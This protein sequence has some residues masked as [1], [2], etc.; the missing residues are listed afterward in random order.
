MRIRNKL[1]TVQIIMTITLIFSIIFFLIHMEKTFRIKDAEI[2]LNHLNTAII[3]LNKYIAM[4][5]N[6][7]NNSVFISEGLSI[8]LREQKKYIDK[9]QASSLYSTQ[10]LRQS[11]KDLK[12]A[13]I[14]VESK[15][16]LQLSKE[17]FG[18]K[19]TKSNLLVRLH[20]ARGALEISKNEKISDSDSEQTS[21]LLK[22]N[23]SYINLN[24]EYSKFSDMWTSTFVIY[25]NRLI[26]FGKN[27]LIQ[28][29]VFLIIIIFIALY[30]SYRIT[31]KITVNLNEVNESLS[32]MTSGD[33][34]SNL[35]IAAGD[36]FGDLSRN[37]NTF[38][39]NL[40]KK[41][42]S[43]NVIMNDIGSAMN[44]DLN[45]SKIQTNILN[46][47]TNHIITDSAAIFSLK[48]GELK[49]TASKGH[50][51]PF[52]PIDKD[53]SNDRPNAARY[54]YENEIPL[55]TE[56]IERCITNQESI[57]IKECFNDSL[58]PQCKKKKSALYINS[59][60]M[61]PLSNAGKVIG[62][63]AVMRTT[64]KKSFS[65]LD[66]SNFTSFSDY[67]A[68]TIDTLEKYNELLDKFEMQ[69]EIGVAA[70]IQSS[71]V[72][73][74]MPKIKGISSSAFTLTAKGVSGD[75]YDFFRMNKNTIGATVCD[76]AGKGVPASLVMVMI[77]TI[78]RL[79]SSP[80]RGAAETLTM[81]NKSISGKIDVDRYATMAFFKIDLATMKLNY[82]NA[83]H[84][85]IQIYRPT[86]HKFY[87]ID[88]PGL[89]IG[90]D[91]DA[92]FSEK[93]V[94]IYPGDVIFM[95]T[96][97]FPEAR[98]INGDEYSTSRMMREI[99]LHSNSSADTILDCVIKDMHKFTARAKQHDD[100]T[101]LIIKLDEE[102]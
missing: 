73:G 33:F 3:S 55:D 10:S 23:E 76:V 47:I 63:L 81:L 39:D 8:R 15:A 68:L 19:G 1:I 45:L 85:P 20:G 91:R 86:T 14:L 40:W 69:K 80:K 21:Q 92:T 102:K 57:I 26:R 11:L 62:L 56:N 50:F 61:V 43:M 52:Y 101:I 90:I 59:F 31:N 88:S 71:L 67:A 93:R 64:N 48:E 35:H 46:N 9:M 84:H 49:M 94:S 18:L 51:P 22:L 27:S 65:D 44:E 74:T 38:I 13:Y 83:A 25:S 53:L 41:L 79:V 24:N 82:S 95:Y 75:Y 17:L 29:F 28:T 78:L 32:K 98:N 4:V 54:L 89:P 34:T 7:R 97:G 96:D 36:E 87:A 2:N 58:F 100:Q 42:D 60:M 6:E 70:D 16:F 30:L 99:R 66:Y 37:F 77:R 12:V 72:P 5:S